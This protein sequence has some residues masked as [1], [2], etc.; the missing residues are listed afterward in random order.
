MRLKKSQKEAVIKWV[1]AGYKTD[2]IN[3]LASDFKPPFKVSRR[4][5]DHY[6]QTRGVDI[7]IIQKAGEEDALTEGLAVKGERVRRLKQL[8]A[9]MEKDLFGGFLWLDQIKGVGSGLLATVVD[10]EEFNSAEVAAYR[11][12]LDDIAKEVGHRAQRQELSGPDG[13]E[14]KAPVYI[15][16]NR[17][18]PDDT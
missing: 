6:R 12:V 17:P 1:T 5:V 4:Q 8:A 2:E 10:Y 9:L 16:E 13:S 15:I 11:G 14:L 18:K 7:T 3:K